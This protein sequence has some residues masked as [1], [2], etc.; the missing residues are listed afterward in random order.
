MEERA[1][2]SWRKMGAFLGLVPEDEQP[3]DS[4][5][6]SD[7][8][9]GSD[10]GAYRTDDRAAYRVDDHGRDLNPSGAVPPPGRGRPR[11][12]Y[13]EPVT[14]GSLAV[15][16]RPVPSR[17]ETYLLGESASGVRPQTVKLTGF[18]EA[19]IIG[20]RYREGS[21][22]ILDM[23]DLSD[24][25]ARRVVDFAAGLAFALRGSIDKV[26]TRVFML[27]PPDADVSAEDRR[28]FAGTYATR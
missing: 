19:R 8:Y 27:I 14:Q 21:W 5:E 28:A 12:S 3:G 16:P 2:G 7:A 4:Y 20:E 10:Y 26:T 24:S 23:T 13:A 9:H 6:E 1:M 22:V 15:Q 17:A 18:G 25:D 11:S